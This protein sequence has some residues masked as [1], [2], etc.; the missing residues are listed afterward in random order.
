MVMIIEN[1]AN[2]NKFKTMLELS[3]EPVA[4]KFMKEALD[5]IP[6]KKMRYC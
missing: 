5:S 4:I 2:A 6:Q 1:E 3:S